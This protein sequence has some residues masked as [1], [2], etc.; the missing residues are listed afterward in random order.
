MKQRADAE[1]IV[2]KVFMEVHRSLPTLRTPDRLGPWL[3]RTARNAVVDHY[4]TPA[5]HREVPSGDASD[6]DVRHPSLAS[7]DDDD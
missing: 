7:T 4:R 2:Q 5:R 6:L 1:D 3:Y